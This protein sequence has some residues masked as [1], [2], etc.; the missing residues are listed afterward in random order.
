[1]CVCRNPEHS[2]RPTFDSIYDYLDS[3]NES[4]LQWPA[5]G[6]TQKNRAPTDKVTDVK[7]LGAPLDQASEL[8]LDLQRTYQN[9]Q[10]ES[11]Q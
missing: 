5:T 4:L 1:V 9:P 2:C 11:N 6:S 10:P 3:P 8:Y 7:A